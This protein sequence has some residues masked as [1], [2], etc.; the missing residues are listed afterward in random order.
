MRG[1]LSLLAELEI[2]AK[3]KWTRHTTFN[4]HVRNCGVFV[5]ALHITNTAL[6]IIDTGGGKR[7]QCMLRNFEERNA[8]IAHKGL[9]AFSVCFCAANVALRTTT[10]HKSDQRARRNVSQIY[11]IFDPERRETLRFANR[12][13][14]AFNGIAFPV[15]NCHFQIGLCRVKRKTR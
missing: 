2:Y 5:V 7:L 9:H 15:V 12:W 11:R 8:K 4:L 13:S 3:Y 14:C 6:H 1:I 10:T